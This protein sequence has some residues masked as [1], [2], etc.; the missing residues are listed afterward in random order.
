[1]LKFM[2]AAVIATVIAIPAMG[3]A[4]DAPDGGEHHWP[5]PE[6]IAACK[7]KNEG[8]TCSFVGHHGQVEGTCRKVKSG[9]LASVHPHHHEG[10]GT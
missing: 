3:S 1:M 5:R 7:D 2:R 6:A 4:D 8:D 9:D 10:S